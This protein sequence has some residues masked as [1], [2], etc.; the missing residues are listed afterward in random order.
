[1]AE[2]GSGTVIVVVIAIVVNVIAVVLIVIFVV[3]VVVFTSRKRQ[4]CRRPSRQARSTMASTVGETT[5]TSNAVFSL[6]QARK[7]RKY[8]LNEVA[9]WDQGR[10]CIVEQ[11]FLKVWSLLKIRTS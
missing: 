8:P 10:A 9:I 11:S 3:V 1:M 2:G 5:L 4:C 7:G 6:R